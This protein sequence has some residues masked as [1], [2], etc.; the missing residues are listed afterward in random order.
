MEF[1]NTAHSVK[2]FVWASSPG[3]LLQKLL[4]AGYYMR[5]AVL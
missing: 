4:P 1:N 2:F 5:L 3:I